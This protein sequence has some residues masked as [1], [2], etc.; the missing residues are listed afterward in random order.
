MTVRVDSLSPCGTCGGK[1]LPLVLCAS[2]GAAAV[3]RDTQELD[4]SAACPECGTFNAWEL[5]CDACRTRSPAPGRPAS[6]S[7]LASPAPGPLG[8]RRAPRLARRIKGD[9]DTRAMADLLKVL[10][11]DARR[12]QALIDRG[13]DAPW[14]FAQVKEGVLARIPE[15]G[16]AAARKILASFRLVSYSPP[17]RTKEAIAQDEYACPLCGC[18]TSA[19]SATCVECG[20]TFDEEEMEEDVRESFAAEGGAGLLAYYDGRLAENPNDWQLSYARGLLLGSLGRIDEAI[21]ALDRAASLGGKD[22]KKARVAQLRFRARQVPNPEDAEK[23]RSSL[24]A[25]LEDAAWEQEVAQLD[26]LLAEVGRECPQCGTPVPLEVALC[27]SC[28]TSLTEPSPL[29]PPKRREPS[30]TPE[31]DAV[32]DDLLVGELE[33]SLSAEELELTKAAVLDWL[34]LELE[35]TMAPETRVLRPTESRPEE[36]SPAEAPA[37]AAPLADSMGFLSRWVQGSRGLVSGARPKS[38]PRGGGRVNGLVNGQ[39]RVNG[40]VNGVGRTNGLV[41]GLGRVNGLATPVGR[42]NGLVTTR[43]RVNGLVGVR[44]RINGIAAGTPFARGYAR[45]PGLPYPSRRVRYAATF[46]GIL[47]AIVIGGLLVFPATG[48]EGPIAIDG[49]FADWDALPKFDAATAAAD[50]NVSIDRYAALSDRE[51][52]YLFASTRGTIFGDPIDY[53]GV[54]FLIDGDG[55]TTTGYSFDD[56]GCEAVVEM[57]GGSRRIEATRLYSFDVGSE[58]NWSQRQPR[59]FARAASSDRQLEAM[60]S[61]LDIERFNATSFRIG[62]YADDFRGATSRSKAFLTASG[63]MILAESEPLTSLLSASPTN[64]FQV[65]LRG[66]GIPAGTGWQ[67]SDFIFNA[68]TGATVSLSPASVTLTQNQP[69]ATLIAA[70]SAPGFSAGEVVEVALTGASAP[71]PIVVRGAPVRAYVQAPPSSIQIDGLFSDWIGRDLL[72]SDPVRVN[73]PDVDIVRSGAA[74]GPT[75]AFF[76]VS[77]AGDLLSGGV[78]QRFVRTA[79]APGGNATGRPIPLP[80]VTGEDVLRVYVDTNVSDA[81]GWSFAGIRADYLLEVRG[82]GG[83]VRSQTLSTWSNG[84]TELPGPGASIAKNDTDIE[85]SIPLGTTNSTALV[86]AATDWSNREDLTTPFVPLAPAPSKS[87]SSPGLQPLHGGSAAT[88]VAQVLTNGAATVDGNCATSEYDGA[89]AFSATDLSG[90]VGTASSYVYVCIDVTGDSDDD[91]AD[92]AAIYFDT[93]H[94]GGTSPA[95]DDRKFRVASGLGTIESWRGNGITW[96]A[97]LSDC[98]SGNEA[99]GEF[100][101]DHPVYEFKIHFANVWG[102]D[103]PTADQRAGFAVIAL[104]AGI[105][106]STFTWGS[107]SPPTDTN[108]ST[109]GHIDIPEYQTILVPVLSAVLVGLLRR[110]RRQAT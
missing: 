36:P 28:G 84:W 83:R 61:T 8:P 43:G 77:V 51:S 97:C 86:F 107:T 56:L 103:S 32:V 88:A 65:R 57:L 41:N 85:G 102:T 12:A 59:G 104:D 6:P 75:T 17:K 94:E 2:C 106:G 15:V 63:G 101:T 66:L 39:G 7:A 22:A 110:W 5:I 80:R 67:V 72:D 78:P 109:W 35:E 52:L 89:G 58:V 99:R 40:L 13:Y 34:I 16:P 19:F 31:L 82:Q 23:I 4:W 46:A 95:S 14:K 79:S 44:G 1:L 37:P 33:K 48:P 38:G 30:P 60:V 10:G 96:V 100:Q 70:V 92:D 73:D 71:Q 74:A 98:D 91:V 62:V 29:P 81:S 69:T 25:L 54:Y 24:K 11:I 50:D 3:L 9:V 108:P 87:S 93:N 76:H 49:S 68:T 45:G 47:A 42:V 26:R 64:L 27:P 53:D 105:G 21:A 18:V 20:A 55:N 90:K